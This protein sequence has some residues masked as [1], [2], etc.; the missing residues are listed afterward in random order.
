MARVILLLGG[1]LGQMKQTL[2]AAQRLI[3]ARI[4]A[5]LRC[6]HRY[7]SKAWGFESEK[8][9][10]N[11]AVE[12]TTDLRP[13]EILL[14]IHSIE[15][16][17]GRDRKA[18]AGEKAATGVRYTSRTIDIDIMF[19]DDEIISTPD[20]EIPHPRMG[21]REFALVPLCEIARDRIHPVTGKTLREM[22]D[23]LKT[24]NPKYEN[25]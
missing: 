9:F 13:E 23:E 2:H 5:V 12:I 25:K 8:M 21:E 14:E 4:G 3:N 16:E 20:L 7:E 15:H 6:S 17:L 19:Y 18:E 10:S 11:Q 24:K 22:L 1:N